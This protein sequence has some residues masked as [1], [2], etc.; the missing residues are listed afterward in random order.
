M[1]ENH[2]GSARFTT[3]GATSAGAGVTGQ[4]RLKGRWEIE[5]RGPD[6]SLKWKDHIDNDVVNVGLDHLLGVT[7]NRVTQTNTWHVGL[8]AASPTV[9][10]ADT[11]SSHAGWTE[12]TAYAETIRQPWL[13]GSI[14]TTSHQ[15]SNTNSKAVFSVNANGTGIGGAFLSAIASKAGS[16][17]ILYAVGAFAGGDKT[18]SSGDTLSV[19][20]TFSTARA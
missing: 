6:G 2:K 9:S 16:E 7:L 1:S 10:S 5:C 13:F 14:D 3:S 18:L 11:A 12:V 8:T 19:G 15:V 4:S 20:A 17:G